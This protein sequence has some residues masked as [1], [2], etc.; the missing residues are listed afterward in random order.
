L[1]NVA[2]PPNILQFIN[3]RKSVFDQ[4]AKVIRLKIDMFISISHQETSSINK[5]IKTRKLQIKI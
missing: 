5:N 4:K 1:Q 2:I 3:E